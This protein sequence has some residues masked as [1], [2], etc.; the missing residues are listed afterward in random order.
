VWRTGQ[1]EIADI[2]DEMLQQGARDDEH[3]RFLREMGL[4]SYICVPMYTR[5]RSLGAITFISAE[6]NQSYTI[7]DLHLAQDM[8]AR[9]ANAVENAR[10]YNEA[11]QAREEAETANRAKDEF[12]AVVSH[13]AAHAAQRHSGLVVHAAKRSH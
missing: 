13:E 11:Q 6:S 8:A 4:K 9:A 10:L 3:L 12:L 2:P 5:G 1:P 7:D